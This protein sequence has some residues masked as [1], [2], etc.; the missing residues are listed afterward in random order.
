MAHF[1]PRSF[2]SR[3]WWTRYRRGRFGLDGVAL[4]DEFAGTEE[5]AA[6]ELLALPALLVPSPLLALLA[7]PG[8]TVLALFALF[9]VGVVA[10][11][12]GGSARWERATWVPV[13][14]PGSGSRRVDSL[15]RASTRLGSLGSGE[16]GRR[17]PPVCLPLLGRLLESRPSLPSELLPYSAEGSDGNWLAG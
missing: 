2:I 4:P 11:C 5:A 9:A 7:L 6:E 12:G 13:W 8:V 14:W 16:P 3:R 15:A 10:G 1:S 17:W